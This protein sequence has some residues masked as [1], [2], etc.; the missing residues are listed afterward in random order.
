MRPPK[1]TH[2]HREHGD[3]HTEADL[4]GASGA[5]Y[6]AKPERGQG[7]VGRPYRAATGGPKHIG[8]NA[9]RGPGQG[10]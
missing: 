6:D 10:V 3:R 2:I 1:P 7:M 9:L 4:P 5:G 8:R